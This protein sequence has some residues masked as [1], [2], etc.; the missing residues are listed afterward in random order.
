MDPVLGTH[1]ANVRPVKDRVV[2]KAG[3]ALEA[4]LRRR[5]RSPQ[6]A[7]QGRIAARSWA[8][9]RA[10]AIRDRSEILTGSEI[11]VT[12]V[13]RA[14]LQSFERLAA[15][16]GELTVRMSAT[17]ISPGTERAQWLRLPHAR[18]G[19]P[20][21]P[22]FSGAGTVIRSDGSSSYSTGDRVALLRAT[23]ASLA[24]TPTS[25]AVP[26]PATVP[27]AAASLTYLAVIAA[28]GV[29][30]CNGVAGRHVVVIG[31]GTIGALAQRLATRAGATTTVVA[32]TERA[33]AAALAG[34][35]TGFVALGEEDPTHVRS[36]IDPPDVVIE[37]T[38]T[39]AGLRLAV[40]LAPAETT[41]VQ[42]GT[43][44]GSTEA[45]P[46][47]AVQQKRLVV[48]GAHISS[49]A[50][51]AQRLGD[52]DEVF[53]RLA[54][55]YLEAVAD[56]LDVSHL[57]GP[58]LDPR[59]ATLAYR[60]LASGDI[61]A[62]HFD[63]ESLP[64]HERVTSARLASRP[65][66]AAPSRHVLPP[67]PGDGSAVA[68][69]AGTPPRPLRVSVVG[70]GDIGRSNARAV[71]SAPSTVLALCQ[72]VDLDLARAAAA[73]A[74]AEPTDDFD[75]AIDPA[76]ADAV[77]LSVPH[78][79]HEPLSI[80]AIENGLHVIIEKPMAVDL[81]S[82]RRMAD[83]ADQAGVHLTT[84]FPYRHDADVV[85]AARLVREGALGDVHGFTIV[86]HADKPDAYWMG[87]FSGRSTSDWRTHVDQA[88]GGV[89]I[90]NVT[91]HIDLLRHITGADPSEVSAFVRDRDGG[92]IEEQAVVAVRL[93]GGAV[94]TLAASSETPGA[95]A[96]RFEIWGSHGTIRIAPSAEVFTERAVGGARPGE[97]CAFPDSPEV[98]SRTV[99]VERFARAIRDG[100]QTDVTVEDGLA[101]QAFID[102]A[103]RSAA[104]GVPVTVEPA[105]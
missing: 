93:D 78:H 26:V 37:A 52:V 61:H 60:R 105:R 16:P 53:A 54:R 7:E 14:R 19:L 68:G 67:G 100:D 18:P 4:V 66:P 48:S 71:T 31:A 46:L 40:E 82:A 103:Y 79:L 35:A 56:G 101:V 73:E 50:T 87:G 96:E 102:A 13:G 24:T 88:G 104:N 28:W 62:G 83:A 69:G 91:H 84:C 1:V 85:T 5:G 57:V 45:V 3:A 59:E 95:P 2:A 94:G 89:L 25:W 97:W 49:L 64:P 92:G 74:G 51:H 20:H 43:P 55:S 36:R 29:E 58:A 9:T 70:C 12:A 17:S 44:R 21:R 63:W 41:I 33:R 39:S 23:H 99:F 32:R 42:L 72:D 77:L 27:L 75:R 76:V 15:G 90:M 8:A 22:G 11:V 30:R 65:I 6:E 86:F 80:A 81:A 98:A 47:R 34:G 38:G 10:S